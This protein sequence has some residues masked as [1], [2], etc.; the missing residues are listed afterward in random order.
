M[1]KKNKSPIRV[2]TVIQKDMPSVNNYFN[3]EIGETPGAE[4]VINNMTK[5]GQLE[6]EEI[7]ERYEKNGIK[8][9]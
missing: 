9:I 2:D 7:V 5:K 1:E 3:A 6:A 8:T 4:S